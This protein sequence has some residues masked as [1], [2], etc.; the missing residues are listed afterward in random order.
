LV[1]R[2]V[3][4]FVVG[5]AGAQPSSTPSTSSTTAP[6]VV[7][8]T[9]PPVVPSSLSSSSSSH[10][11][12][13]QR[14]RADRIISVFENGTM[15]IR[16]DYVER[17]SDGRGYTAGRGFTTGTGDVLAVVEDYAKRSPRNTLERYLGALR[18]LAAAHSDAITGLEGFPA[19]WTKA[20][21]TDP[22]FRKCQD[23]EVD[24]SSYSPAMEIA[25]GLGLKTALGR[26]AMYDAIF[27]HGP[28]DDP[29]G[30]PALV[31]AATRD[32]RGAP[33]DGVAEPTWL[34]AF[35]R[36]R[37]ATLVHAHDPSTRAEWAKAVGRADVFLDLLA[38]KNLDLHGPIHLGADYD[39]NV[40]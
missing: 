4:L 24:R 16:Y 15:E 2:F 38:A 29:D 23:D 17:L 19:A 40:P 35:F 20:A 1:K 36:V 11:T 8:S 21:K 22:V 37:R 26:F 28:G 25:D 18:K 32:A 10:F 34:L 7:P 31:K 13:E 30:L 9:A 39:V 6:P 33:K 27:M 12:P 5:C 3:L 14:L